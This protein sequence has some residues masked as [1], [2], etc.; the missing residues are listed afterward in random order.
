MRFFDLT[1]MELP[2]GS[3]DGMP[4][5]GPDHIRT[6]ALDAIIKGLQGDVDSST[7]Q[8]R[9]GNDWLTAQFHVKDFGFGRADVLYLN[10]RVFTLVAFGPEPWQ[11]APEFKRFFDSF[12]VKN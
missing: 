6:G 8:Q 11:T 10:G 5:D 12:E 3:T 9:D 4:S 1:Y 7:T 2:T